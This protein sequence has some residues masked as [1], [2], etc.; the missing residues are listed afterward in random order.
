VSYFRHHV[1][2]CTNERPADHPRGCCGAERGQAIADAFK[3]HM[4]IHGIDESRANKAGC[5]DRCELGPCVVV[6]PEGIWYRI[7]DIEHDV[8]LIV[9]QHL[10]DGRPVERLQ[11]PERGEL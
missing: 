6:Y 8:S 11:L 10:R 4:R 2:C 1:F 3:K 9:Q 7:D 5:L